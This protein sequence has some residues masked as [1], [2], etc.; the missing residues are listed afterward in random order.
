V[1]NLLT[2]LATMGGMS[3]SAF[4]TVRLR[5]GAHSAP[6][7]GACVFELVSIGASASGGEV[8]AS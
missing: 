7:R 1:T 5:R 2:T 4:Q 8:A 6:E 3:D